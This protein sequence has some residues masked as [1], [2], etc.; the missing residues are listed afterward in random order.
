MKVTINII[1]FLGL[2][3]LTTHAS[4]PFEP[5]GTGQVLEVDSGGNVVWSNTVNN[6]NAASTNFLSSGNSVTDLSDV[7]SA[8]SGNIITESERLKLSNVTDTGSGNIITILE[9][10]KLTNLTDSG[11]GNII[12]ESERLK[13]SNITDTGSGNIMTS[14]ERA[15]LSQLLTSSANYLST[16]NSVTDLIDI[17][18]SGSG[19]VI[20]SSE[21]SKVTQLTDKPFHQLENLENVT[22]LSSMTGGQLYGV[23]T[24]PTVNVTADA[25][26]LYTEDSTNSLIEVGIY[27]SS[28]NLL[29]NGSSTTSATGFLQVNLNSS[30]EL[31]SGTKYHFVVSTSV[32]RSFADVNLMFGYF[33]VKTFRW[34][35]TS[36]STPPASVS[37]A[38]AVKGKNKF[39]MRTVDN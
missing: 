31:S 2:F 22:S 6:L 14:N 24:M 25:I 12:T 17:Y 1:G 21:R 18:H 13:L 5:G 11:S 35:L 38:S 7:S 15:S 23:M 9:R 10:V 34:L 36:T 28:F 33:K 26:E 3:A 20:T 39:W 8:G 4:F 30:I 29:T 27:D 19:N 32:T 37:F 16:G